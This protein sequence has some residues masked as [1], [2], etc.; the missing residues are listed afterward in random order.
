MRLTPLLCLLAIGCAHAP[1]GA[2]LVATPADVSTIQKRNAER[3]ARVKVGMP[4]AEF[5]AAFPEAYVGGQNRDVT[6][7]EISDTRQIPAKDIGVG[8]IFLGRLR[9]PEPSRRAPGPLVLLPR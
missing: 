1:P 6:A 7:Y 3:L 8:H 5:R 2:E 4:A 9:Q